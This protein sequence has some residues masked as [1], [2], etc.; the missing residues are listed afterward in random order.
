[1]PCGPADTGIV[2]TTVPAATSITLTVLSLKLPTYAFGPAASAVA[3]AR[4]KRR[5]SSKGSNSSHNGLPVVHGSHVRR[6]G[7]PWRF[8][9]TRASVV[10]PGNKSRVA[11]LSNN[12]GD[13][14]ARAPPLQCQVL[15]HLDA[16]YNL[17][18]WLTRDPHDA[19]DV[20]QDACMRA[21]RYV[22]TLRSGGAKSSFLTVV[23][24]AFY[25]WVARNRPVE[26]GRT[27]STPSTRSMT[28]SARP[29]TGSDSPGR[30]ARARRRAAGAVAAVSRGRR[31]AR[32]GGS[33][34]R[35]IASVMGVPVGTVMSRLARAR[36]ML[37][38]VPS[39]QP[40]Q[41]VAE[42]RR[43]S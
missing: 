15:P 37:R 9:P 40:V 20:V 29:A 25:D 24:H 35:E 10:I 39:L 36:A 7:W 8:L 16:A 11:G 1:M 31:A 23:R 42:T 17:A 41:A 4:V 2:V 18:R 22:D 30:C 13:K 19:E 34:V 21:F 12:D 5:Y 32:V 33:V 6:P 26:I 43:Q 3:A 38:R 14:R 28:W 27:D